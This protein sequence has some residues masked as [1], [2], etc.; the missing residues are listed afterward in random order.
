MFIRSRER[1]SEVWHR[2]HLPHEG[3]VLTEHRGL[4]E[5]RIVANADW[6]VELFLLLTERL[7]PT[8]CVSL[9]DVRT[10]RRWSRG[11]LPLAAARD[12]ALR[13]RKP[14]V[15]NAGVECAFYD[16][17]DQITLSPHMEV[18]VYG[19]SDRWFYFLRDLGLERRRA[20]P[21]RSWHLAR[22]EF[23]PAP[24]LEPALL[25]VVERLG[26]EAA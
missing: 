25:E 10:N 5:A 2:F 16:E 21:P 8:V 4:F 17:D 6:A 18:F 3:F 24:A 7:S 20:L 26:L 11:T 15:V 14:L 23:P 1:V 9:E 22:H 13:L 19:R 12:A